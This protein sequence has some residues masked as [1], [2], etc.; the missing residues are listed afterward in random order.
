MI[1]GY[2][3]LSLVDKHKYHMEAIELTTKYRKLIDK[4]VAIHTERIDLIN[5]L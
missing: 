2:T 3:V 1:N 4:H 5:K